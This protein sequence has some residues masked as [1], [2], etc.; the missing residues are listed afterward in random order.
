M[1]KLMI[2]IL[3]LLLVFALSFSLISCH[4]TLVGQESVEGPNSLPEFSV[5]ESFDTTKQYEIVFWAKNE[6]NKAQ[7]EVYRRAITEFEALYP[8]VK[9][10]M[11]NYTDYG[12]IYQDVITNIGTGTTPNVCIS[13][14]DHIATYLTGNNIVVPLDGLIA[15]EKYGLGGSEVRFDSVKREEM[16]EK[17]LDEGKIGGVQY[18]LPFMRSTEA[19]YVNC[20]LIRALGFEVPEM[21]TW[22]FVWEVCRAAMEKNADGSFKANGKDVMIPL[23]YKST[24]NMMIQMLAQLEA[25][26][27]N[28]NGEILI[29]G[30]TAKELLLELSEHARALEYSTFKIKGYPGN[31]INRGQCIF[32]I[33]STAGA[34]WMGTDAPNIDI[35]ESELAD[36]EIKVMAIPQFDTEKPKMISQGPS[37][38]V[39]N[40]GDSGEVLASWLFAQYLLTNGIQIAYSQTEGYAPVTQKAQNSEEYLKYLAASG[41]DNDLHYSVKIDAAKLLLESTENSFVTPVFNGSASLRNAA[42]QLIESI[43]DASRKG[44]VVTKEDIDILYREVS[45]LY[46]LDVEPG[47]IAPMS[48]V[49]LSAIFV[50]DAVIIGYLVWK[51]VRK[52]KEN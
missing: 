12:R 30:D 1:R 33:D 26:Y 14:P 3:T 52:K 51:K 10:T 41:T 38:C 40:K 45:S 34:S 47:K 5:P 23:I 31:Y 19:C 21:L 46:R 48:V 49:L 11:K 29:F 37:L 22:D 2:K 28:E 39:F 8:N 17:F 44:E 20:D 42:G 35:P 6:S 43:T 15:D 36:Y 4:G 50:T 16:V 27:S 13:Y 7:T 24:D 9:V 18:A 25:P 32:A